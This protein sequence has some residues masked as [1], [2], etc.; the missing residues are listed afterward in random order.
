MNKTPGNDDARLNNDNIY[1]YEP[2][3]TPS[4]PTTMYFIILSKKL[5]SKTPMEL[6]YIERS[7]FLNEVKN[8]KTWNIELISQERMNDPI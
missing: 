3:F 4:I 2:H 1:W 5:L 7:V 8:P 6:R